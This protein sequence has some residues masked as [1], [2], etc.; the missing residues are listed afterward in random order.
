VTTVNE[1]Q[2]SHNLAL[3]HAWLWAKASEVP[4]ARLLGDGSGLP[5]ALL[6]L[7]AL[8]NVRRAA[9]MAKKSLQRPAAQQILADALARFDERLPGVNAARDV[10]EHL[11]E[12]AVGEGLEQRR[13][14][15]ATPTLT[16]P[17]LAA[18]YALRLEGTY[19]APIVRVGPYSIE[20]INVPGAAGLLF[21]GIRGAAEAEEE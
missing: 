11:D 19:S 17:E 9:D 13:L 1:L 12:Y 4:A 8:R 3:S 2:P 15:D 7:V 14:R 10:I 5:D 18:R 6:L 20:A 21:K 16:H